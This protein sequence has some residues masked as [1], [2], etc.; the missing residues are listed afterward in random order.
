MGFYYQILVLI[1]FRLFHCQLYL[2]FYYMFL[3]F[4]TCSDRVVNVEHIVSESPGRGSDEQ[5]CQIFFHDEGAVLV[6]QTEQGGT[7]RTSLQPQKHWSCLGI[8]LGLKKLNY[9]ETLKIFF[10]QFFFKQD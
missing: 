8:E 7:T 4:R 6:E 1:V 10:K 3:G 5:R 9:F 2:Y